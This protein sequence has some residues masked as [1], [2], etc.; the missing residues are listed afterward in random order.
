ME[1]KKR[2]IDLERRVFNN[3]WTLDFFFIDHFGKCLCLICHKA[4]AVRKVM[5]IKRHYETLHSKYKDLRGIARV[6]EV[7]K[8]KSNF[9]AQS[10]FFHLNIEE[11]DRTTRASF[12]VLRLIA[13]RMKPFTDG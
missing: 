6:N 8:L 7:A 5:N 13:A 4:I 3:S 1:S 12:E 11:I 9:T 2:K 10:S